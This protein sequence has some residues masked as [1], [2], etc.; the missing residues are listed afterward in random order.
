MKTY[1]DDYQRNCKPLGASDLNLNT[2]IIYRSG[3]FS[4][5]SPIHFSV[6]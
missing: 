6:T 5:T 4:K 2:T 1:L 3:I